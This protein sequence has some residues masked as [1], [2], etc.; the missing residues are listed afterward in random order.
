MIQEHCWHM[1]LRDG[2]KFQFFSNVDD[3]TTNPLTSISG[4]DIGDYWAVQA[5]LHLIGPSG[6]PMPSGM[7][8]HPL[9]SGISTADGS[10]GILK[11]DVVSVY[12]SPML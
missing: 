5:P 2:T 9:A 4:F 8:N 7:A 3:G 6:G 1:E 11:S 12:S 10:W